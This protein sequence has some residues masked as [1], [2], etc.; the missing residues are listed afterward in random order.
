[1][2]HHL[3]LTS[4][5]PQREIASRPAYDPA[6]LINPDEA[7]VRTRDVGRREFFGFVEATFSELVR[8]EARVGG[9]APSICTFCRID[10]GLLVGGSG[11]PGYFVNEVE[12]TPTTSLWFAS[13]QERNMGVMVDTF[14]RV[15][16]QWLIA[17]KNLPYAAP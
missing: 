10:V 16:E 3:I 6:Q 8:R 14:A 11:E 5:P 1:M 13:V 7:D 12:R 4:V 15:F 9:A 17:M 2:P